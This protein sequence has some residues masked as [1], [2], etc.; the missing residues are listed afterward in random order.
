[1]PVAQRLEHQ[2]LSYAAL[3]AGAPALFPREYGE[4]VERVAAAMALV[5]PAVL[6]LP[7]EDAAGL[8][9][10]LVGSGADLESVRRVLVLGPITADERADLDEGLAAA[11][12]T[13]A[14]VLALYGPAEGRVMWA[15]CAPGSGFHT[16]PD[17]DLVEVI[18]AETGVPAPTGELVLTQLGFRGSALLRW[19]T[20]DV[21]EAPLATDACS[22]GRTVPRIP[23]TVHAG[24]FVR[25]MRPRG[26][27]DA[28]VDLRAVAGALSGRADVSDWRIEL[29]RSA[30][31]GTDELVVFVVPE[32]DE[33]DAAVNV[34]RDVRSVSGFTASQVVVAQPSEL[35]ALAASGD[36]VSPRISV[37][38]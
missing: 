15:E 16:Y 34:Y 13:R 30:R 24:P 7:R 9:A 26:G 37:R 12:A 10:D 2:F 14:Q 19:R 3:G 6:A 35:A 28:K 4:G 17:L 32:G 29:R 31:D 27:V 22:C 5:R 11:G 36:A 25:M 21:V 1:V 8:L 20:G 18:D 38:A 23:S 33:S